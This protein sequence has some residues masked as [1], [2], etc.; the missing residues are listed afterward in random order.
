MMIGRRTRKTN[1]D[2]KDGRRLCA[3]DMYINNLV[4]ALCQSGDDNNY[5]ST[6][7]TDVNC[8]QTISKRIHYGKFVAESKF[9]ARGVSCSSTCSQVVD[10]PTST[11]VYFFSLHASVHTHT[12]RCALLPLVGGKS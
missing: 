11:V 6:G 7:L 9:Q 2:W 10:S 5:G 1:D 4:P 8:L 12:V 3:E